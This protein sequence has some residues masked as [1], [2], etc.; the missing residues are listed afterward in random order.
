MLLPSKLSK[1]NRSKLMQFVWV[2]FAVIMAFGESV[3][4]ANSSIAVPAGKFLPP[5]S[6]TSVSL[7][8]FRIDKFPVTESRTSI[9]K[10]EVTWFEAEAYCQSQG[11][12]LPTTDEWEYAAS[13]KRA[14]DDSKIIQRYSKPIS[15]TKPLIVGRD[16]P[17]KLEIHDLYGLMWEWT[18]DFNA[19]SITAKEDKFFCG[20][21]SVEAKDPNQYSTFMRYAYRSSLKAKYKA[22]NLG[23]R[24]V[25]DTETKTSISYSKSNPSS[26]AFSNLYA[27]DAQWTQASGQHRKTSDLAG[28]VR[29]LAMIYTRCKVV[30]PL[31]TNYMRKLEQSLDGEL[32]NKIRFTLISF[33]TD[34]DDAGHLTEF[35]QTYQLSPSGWDVMVGQ[36]EATRQL[37]QLLAVAYKKEPDDSFKHSGTV[38]IISEAGQILAQ[39]SPSELTN[40]KLRLI[41]RQPAIQGGDE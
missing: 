28:K 23:F 17:N 13:F 27:I 24:C 14:D 32:K 15:A 41:L 36:K 7:K 3:G 35:M 12:R 19:V 38:S 11:G 9:A 16:H 20:A 8:P 30:C 26:P 6:Q 4:G 10:T 29:I 40:Q 33:D 22:R 34:F 31:V 18:A 2:Y 37:A 5:F 25:Y 1:T 21:A 39:L